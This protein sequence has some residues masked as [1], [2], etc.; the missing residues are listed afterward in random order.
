MTLASVGCRVVVV[1]DGCTD[2]AVDEIADHVTHVE[3]SEKNRGKGHALLMGMKAALAMDGCECVV[4]LDADGQHNPAEIP[5]LFEAYCNHDADFVIGAREFTGQQVP[6]RSWFG[7]VITVNVFGML[8]GKRLPDTQS[9][10]RVHGRRFAEDVLRDVDGGRYETE[11]EIVVK[12][13]KGDYTIH[14][15]PIQTVYEP[16]NVS[17]HFHKFRDSALIYRR[18]FR[19]VRKHG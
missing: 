14:S 7:N 8:L 4:T 18:L 3:R 17:S 15:E 19:A 13:V 1:D 16:G 11:M 5:R 10:F 2:G 12:A 9:G 6:L